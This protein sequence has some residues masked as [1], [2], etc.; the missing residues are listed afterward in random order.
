[1]AVNSETIKVTDL[2]VNPENYRFEEQGS[3]KEA[4]EMMIEDQDNDLYNLAK[5]IIENGL[6]PND[7]IQVT[8][9]TD[10]KT[11]VV[12]EG[13]RRVVAL[14]LLLNPDIIDNS[15]MSPLKNKFKKLHNENKTKLLHEVDCNVYDDPSEADKWI[16]LKHTGPN[17]GIGTVKWDAHQRARFDAKMENKSSVSLEAI[18]LIKNSP[19]VKEEIKVKLKNLKFTNLSRLLDDP[20]VRE[21]LGMDTNKGK[22]EL[23]LPKEE[24]VK[25]LSQ[26][27]TDLLEPNFNVMRIYTKEKRKEYLEKFNQKSK[28]NQQLKLE[29]PLQ[30]DLPDAEV[31]KTKRVS[32][33]RQS[34]IPNTCVIKINKPKINN[35]YAE[36]Q[37][38]NVYKFTNA[39]AV[40]L[41]VFV[42]S[43]CDAYIEQNKLKVT[44]QTDQKAKERI[45]LKHKVNAV[46]DDMS[47]KGLVNK[48]VYKGIKTA[49]QSEHNILS[50][51]TWHNYVHNIH[52]SPTPKD[53]ITSWDNI[54]LYMTKLWESM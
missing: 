46:T 24:V 52:F 38:L 23:Y 5:D 22:L 35:I 12:L 53:L 28:P 45:T 2:E 50:I 26:I 19:E 44:S 25:G 49:V 33:D 43:S 8:P 11:F 40:L 17:D 47:A 34:L 4:I 1:M 54:E 39:T 30:L 13:N 37:K 42:E 21:F 16:K 18:K 15:S 36:L 48:S 6:N 32:R 29:K 3:Q 14:K 7:K 31:A 9:S 51:D 27:M 41:R 20:Q 10:K